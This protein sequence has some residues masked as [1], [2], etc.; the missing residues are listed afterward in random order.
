M[1][2]C[3]MTREGRRNPGRLSAGGKFGW[4][5]LNGIKWLVLLLMEMVPGQ[6]AQLG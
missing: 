2:F 1:L 5:M 6:V 3:S 4:N